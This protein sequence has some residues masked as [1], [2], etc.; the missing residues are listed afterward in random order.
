MNLLEAMRIYVRVVE[1]GSISGAA[2]DL[3]IGQPAVSERIERLEKFLGC[4]LLLRNARTFKCTPEGIIFHERS[5]SVLGAVEQALAEVAN[6]EQIVKGTIRIAAPHCFG[7]TILP[8]GLKRVRETYPR[9]DIELVLNDKIADLVTEGVDISFRLGPLGD[10]AYIA[11]PLGQV[12]RL[13]V[14]SPD[15]LLRHAAIDTPSQLAEHNFIRVKGTF[16]ANQLPLA[17]DSAI[18]DSVPIRTTIKTT[19]WRPMYEM[20]IA[21]VGMGVLEEPAATAAI[22]A[23]RLVRVLPDYEVPALAL[24]LLIRPQRPVPARVRKIVETL[25]MF[26]AETFEHRENAEV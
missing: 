18:V 12:R 3:G 5:K 14:A 1:R 20:V 19:H 4:Q 9:L 2:R 10:G 26:V 15:Y 23:G 22:E 6:D 8:E 11:W 25:K 24:N 13:L 7:E 17:L 21:G 16:D